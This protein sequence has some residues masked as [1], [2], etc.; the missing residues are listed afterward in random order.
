MFD[1]KSS[2][3]IDLLLSSASTSKATPELTITCKSP[4]PEAPP[5]PSTSTL[6]KQN[7][8]NKIK[9]E[10]RIQLSHELWYHGNISRKDSEILVSKDGDFLVRESQGSPGQYVLTGMQGGIRKHLLLVD[11]EGVVRTKDKAF[12]SVSHLINY[13]RDNGLP[14]ISAESAL[15]LRNA[16]ANLKKRNN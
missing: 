8:S 12:E 15:I 11:P 16:V 3:P 14:I 4:L 2:S 9:D 1:K 5:L 7:S 6:I 10:Y 13:H